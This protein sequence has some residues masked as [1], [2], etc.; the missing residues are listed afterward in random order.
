MAMRTLH[1][2]VFMTLLTVAVLAQSKLHTAT[3]V[4]Y[5]KLEDALVADP[6][7]N[8]LVKLAFFSSQMLSRDLIYLKVCVTV[9]SVRSLP[10]LVDRVTS[11]IASGFSGA[12]LL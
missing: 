12:V 2:V 9:D 6:N 7:L 11:P 5:Q 1:G 3:Q 10:Y 4:V 8:Y